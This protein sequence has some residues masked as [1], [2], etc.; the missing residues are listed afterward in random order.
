[1]GLQPFVTRSW[2]DTPV[3]AF[4]NAVH[5]AYREYGSGGYTG[6][7][8]EKSDF[9]LI[10]KPDGVTPIAYAKKLMRHEDNDEGCTQEFLNHVS[11]ARRG[12]RMCAAIQETEESW[13]FFGLAS[14]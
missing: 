5:D 8:A 13:L 7:I 4:R 6:S 11:I 1:M 3:E 14:Y 12:N 9:V 10:E 2:G